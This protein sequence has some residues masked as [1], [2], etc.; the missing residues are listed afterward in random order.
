MEVTTA[1]IYSAFLCI[2][3]IKYISENILS[4]LS[5]PGTQSL[6][7]CVN[8]LNFILNPNIKFWLNY[9]LRQLK[10]NQVN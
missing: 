4:N 2:I 8:I 5:P 1:D 6:I 7:N 9:E 10:K 3:K